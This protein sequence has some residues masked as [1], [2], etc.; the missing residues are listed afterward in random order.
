MKDMA[1]LKLVSK[2]G[3]NFFVNRFFLQL[4]DEFYYNLMVDH[5]NDDI[6]LY[7]IEESK[8]SIEMLVNDINYKHI[9]CQKF[10]N[11]GNSNLP[12]INNQKISNQNIKP[13]NE[14]HNRGDNANDMNDTDVISYNDEKKF[15][16]DDRENINHNIESEKLHNNGNENEPPRISDVNDDDTKNVIEDTD[17]VIEDNISV[18]ETSQSILSTDN[19]VMKADQYLQC[20]FESSFTRN[21]S[22]E[23]FAHIFIN[24]RKDI[25]RNHKFGIVRFLKKLEN[26]VSKNCVFNCQLSNTP[27]HEKAHYSMEKHYKK[28]HI[29]KKIEK[30][31]TLEVCSHCDKKIL[32]GSMKR[33][34]ENANAEKTFSCEICG[35]RTKQMR[36]LEEHIRIVHDKVPVK[37]PKCEKV[38]NWNK[39]ESEALLNRHI[40]CVHEG[41]K[42]YVCEICGVKMS[43]YS[44]LDDHRVKVHSAEKRSMKTYYEMI[45]SGKY[46][47]LKDAVIMSKRKIYYS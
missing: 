32:R 47:F 25:R 15:H 19:Q 41:F 29:E 45:K 31:K 42:P 6:A 35:I 12:S 13:E 24:H 21:S 17:N 27:P 20:P 22:D 44:N 34:L 1:T 33:H 3:L 40:K 28:F 37:C 14:N 10:I 11:L 9:N 18:N 2:E 23:M 4:Y 8:A 16:E 36:G 26:D 5:P 39:K 7:F 46:D 38:F 43:Q 30:S